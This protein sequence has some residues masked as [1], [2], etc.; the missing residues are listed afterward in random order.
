MKKMRNHLFLLTISLLLFIMVIPSTSAKIVANTGSTVYS[1]EQLI[2]NRTAPKEPESKSV[3]EAS[4]SDGILDP[5]DVS[6]V[7]TGSKIG[8]F[9]NGEWKLDYNNDG[10]TD[11]SFYFGTSTDIPINGDWNGDGITESGVFRPSVQQFI[12]NTS[13]ITRITF[14]LN[15]DI[16]IT[17]DWNKDGITDVGVF[18]PSVQQ[19]ILNT[20]P[21]TRI[22]YGLSTDIPV[23]G[24]WNND[25][26]TGIGVFRNGNWK[27][28]Y[29]NNG[30]TDTSFYFGTSTDIP[31]TGDWNGDGS[32]DAGVFRPSTRQFILNTVPITRITYGLSTDKPVTGKWVDLKF[33]MTNVEW[34]DTSDDLFPWGS[35]VC[36]VVSNWMIGSAGWSQRF[37]DRDGDVNDL[38]FGSQNSGYQGLDEGQFHYHFGHGDLLSGETYVDYSNYP[39]SSLTRGDVYKKWDETNKWVVFDACYVLAN[40]QWGGTLKY[41]HGILGFSTEKTVSTDLPDQF[42]RNCIYYDYTIGYSWKRATQDI[43]DPDATARVIFDTESQL[44]NDH[45]SGQ[46]YVAPNENPDDDTVYYDS[47]SC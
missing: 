29:D 1:G 44:L 3:P 24:D 2:I 25:G 18:R 30:F 47:W 23:T 36:N 43:Y 7:G 16:P 9:R 41:S 5:L 40:L 11:N 46:G 33:S 19:F 21:I 12:F 8:V 32:T 38:D 31:I 17:G 45:I 37:Y 39:T 20:V 34:Y 10:V 35:N 22:T 15:T 42:L 28:D 26:S 6:L 27:L 4:D 13:P 14:G